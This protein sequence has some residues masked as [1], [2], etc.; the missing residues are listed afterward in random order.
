MKVL[1]YPD[2]GH[3]P[4]WPY[5]LVALTSLADAGLDDHPHAHPVHNDAAMVAFGDDGEVVGFMAY[6][7]DAV[8]CS[9]FILLAWVSEAHR[10]KGAHTAMFQ[11][12]VSR[13]EKRG[14][15]LMIESVTHINNKASQAAFEAQGRAKSAIMYSFRIKEWMDG[16]D[17]CD[18]TAG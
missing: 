10:R 15:I 4:A 9:W 16:K 7:P 1:F 5:V 8:R 2:I 11:A 3:S 12:L 14:D 17:P 6:R 13:A 18:T